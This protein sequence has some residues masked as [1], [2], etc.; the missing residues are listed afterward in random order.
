MFVPPQNPVRFTSKLGAIHLRTRLTW[1]Q[2]D[3]EG[4]GVGSLI[5]LARQPEALAR[6]D[7]QHAL[8]HIIRDEITDARL[9]KRWAKALQ[10]D[11][12]LIDMDDARLL[13]GLLLAETVAE[14]RHLTLANSLTAA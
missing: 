4:P 9:G 7:V 6:R 12:N 3:T 5:E 13:R 11:A 8:D 14:S 2:I 1:M 10:D